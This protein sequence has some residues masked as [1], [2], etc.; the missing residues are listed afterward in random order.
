[1]ASVV[2]S[3]LVVPV[4][5]LVSASLG[6]AAVVELEDDVVVGEL[7]SVVSSVVEAGGGASLH[8]AHSAVARPTWRSERSIAISMPDV[9][10]DTQSPGARRQVTIR[11]RSS[12][13]TAI[14]P[15]VNLIFLPS[16]TERGAYETGTS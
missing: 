13:H 14:S 15:S 16:A 9:W 5:V 1:M 8:A 7:V 2:A 11:K 10:V 12:V 3:A 6:G 4:V